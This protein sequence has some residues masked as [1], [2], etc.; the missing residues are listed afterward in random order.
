M[1]HSFISWA[2]GAQA[3]WLF[4]MCL[5]PDEGTQTTGCY[6]AQPGTPAHSGG[7]IVYVGLYVGHSSSLGFRDAPFSESVTVGPLLLL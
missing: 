7:D 5:T 6:H 1:D 4:K 2:V 3:Y